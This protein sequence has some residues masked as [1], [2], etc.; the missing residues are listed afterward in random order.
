M[1]PLDAF[2]LELE[3]ADAQ[4]ISVKF[5]G[6]VHPFLVHCGLILNR[7]TVVSGNVHV[8]YCTCDSLHLN[9]LQVVDYYER[10]WQG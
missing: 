9:A 6:R 1:R 3:G 7:K 5:T 4:D 10:Q 2:E 8:V